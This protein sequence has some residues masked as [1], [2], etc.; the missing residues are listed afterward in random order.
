MRGFLG[1]TILALIGGCTGSDR[2]LGTPPGP[3]ETLDR[4]IP[5]DANTDGLA[6]YRLLP[7][8]LT[9]LPLVATA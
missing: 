7:E 6:P 2:P 9:K 1:L 4:W 3:E 5:L 8:T